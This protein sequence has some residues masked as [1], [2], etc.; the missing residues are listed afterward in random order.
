MPELPHANA[1]EARGLGPRPCGY[2]SLQDLWQAIQAEAGPQGYSLW[3]PCLLGRIGAEIGPQAMAYVPRVAK[4]IVNRID[5]L[6]AIGNGVLPV[7]A[8]RAWRVLSQRLG[9]AGVERV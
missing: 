4:D 6:R 2:D 7:V 3:R 5:R 9:L 1:H 8:A